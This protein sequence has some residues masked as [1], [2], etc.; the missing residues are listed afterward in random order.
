MT[1]QGPMAPQ[2]SPPGIALGSSFRPSTVK[3][4]AQ[5]TRFWVTPLL[6]CQKWQKLAETHVLFQCFWSRSVNHCNSWGVYASRM[7]LPQ[8]LP[9]P[10]TKQ[11]IKNRTNLSIQGLA[12]YLIR[13]VRKKSKKYIVP[14]HCVSYSDVQKKTWQTSSSHW[15]HV[16]VFCV[17]AMLKK[18]KTKM[19]LHG[20]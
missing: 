18:C 13:N 4:K 2:I 8:L 3:S 10:D 20:E 11:W 6:T 12:R 5:S 15:T 9:V 1:S 14:W 19:R 7:H 17:L 16:C